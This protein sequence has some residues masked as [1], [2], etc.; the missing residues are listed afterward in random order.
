MFEFMVHV[1]ITGPAIREK[2]K[3]FTFAL[4]SPKPCV[5]RCF[6]SSSATGFF[7]LLQNAPIGAAACNRS[8][9]HCTD[10]FKIRKAY[11]PSAF[12]RARAPPPGLPNRG[13]SEERN[14]A[15]PMQRFALARG[16]QARHNT[17]PTKKSSAT[18]NCMRTA[19]AEI[20]LLKV[21][22]DRHRHAR[23][24]SASMRERKRE[25]EIKG[26]QWRDT[27]TKH[28]VLQSDWWEPRKSLNQGQIVHL[29]WLPSLDSR[30]F[31][32]Y[33]YS[34]Y[35]YWHYCLAKTRQTTLVFEWD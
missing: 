34:Y 3:A 31:F 17:R 35:Y 6:V 32:C 26:C 9:V 7:F 21:K 30:V 27:R 33:Y 13:S 5:C 22:C 18:L 1:P 23:D 4:T 8:F 16:Q 14:A 15:W 28:Y 29:P 12:T 20:S 24:C 10:R 25:R 11:P 2:R 19:M